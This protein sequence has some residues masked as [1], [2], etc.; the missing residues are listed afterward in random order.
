MKGPWKVAAAAARKDLVELYAKLYGSKY[1]VHFTPDFKKDEKT[2]R[3]CE[4]DGQFLLLF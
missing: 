2:G 4:F 3:G 1:G